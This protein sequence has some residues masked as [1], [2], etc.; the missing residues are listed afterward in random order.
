MPATTLPFARVQVG[1]SWVR[2]L[3]VALLIGGAK[4]AWS[5]DPAADPFA[6]KWTLVMGLEMLLARMG[7]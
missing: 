5:A 2:A 7:D 4:A 1:G 6:G 3:V